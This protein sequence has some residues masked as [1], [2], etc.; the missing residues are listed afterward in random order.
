MMTC[1]FGGDWVMYS[2]ADAS[3]LDLDT[4]AGAH[5]RPL[6]FTPAAVRCSAR[7]DGPAAHILVSLKA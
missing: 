5:P 4:T 3:A 2:N 6:S 1:L 7:L